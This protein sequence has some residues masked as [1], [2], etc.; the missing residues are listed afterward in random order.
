MR[1]L[2]FADIVFDNV[3][4]ITCIMYCVCVCVY[5]QQKTK[6][7]HSS[8]LF[9]HTHMNDYIIMSSIVSHI[10]TITSK[11]IKACIIMYRKELDT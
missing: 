5:Y 7:I 11:Y 6:Y 1:H 8:R 10:D 2:A 4:S 9:S 3:N